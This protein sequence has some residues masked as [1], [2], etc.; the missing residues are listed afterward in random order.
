[1]TGF[2]LARKVDSAKMAIFAIEEAMKRDLMLMEAILGQLLQS[3]DPLIGS[4]SIAQR[5]KMELPVVRHHLNLLQDKG[6]VQESENSVWRLTN[7]G[8][9]YMEGYPE[10]AISLNLPSK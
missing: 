9:D 4:S 6:L 3:P 5:L 1:M 7:Q 10:Q 8:H 2:A